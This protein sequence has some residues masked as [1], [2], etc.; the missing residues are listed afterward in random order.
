M[1]MIVIKIEGSDV[2]ALTSITSKACF[3]SGFYVQSFCLPHA[4]Y[5]KF[6]KKSISSRQEESPD[7]LI[8]LDGKNLENSLR[9][10][11]EKSSVIIKM[12]EKP[13]SAIAKRRNI[14]FHLIDDEK[15]PVGKD[16]ADAFIFGALTK[17]CSHIMLK[18]A[19]SSVGMEKEI[20]ASFEEG[21]RNVK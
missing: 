3:L 9:F 21:I 14:K 12:K 7:F 10:V 15:I 1:G 16:A 20:Q 19:K 17:I 11:K 4:G 6:D 13:R 2:N 5:V 18:A 8:F